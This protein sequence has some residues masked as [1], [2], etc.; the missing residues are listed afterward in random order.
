MKKLSI[1]IS[2]WLLASLAMWIASGQTK[3]DYTNRIVHGYLQVGDGSTAGEVKMGE[4]SPGTDYVSWLAPNSLTLTTRYLMPD[5]PP[6]GSQYLSCG[7]PSSSISTCAFS[8]GTGG[9]AVAGSGRGF[10]L[11]GPYGADYSNTA[12]KGANALYGMQINIGVG[13][14]AAKAHLYVNTAQASST[15]YIAVYN[16]DCTTKLTSGSVASATTGAKNITLSPSYALAAGQYYVMLAN[17]TASVTIGAVALGTIGSS[18]PNNGTN[19]TWGTAAN[20]LSGGAMPSACG[21]ITGAN[22]GATA[23]FPY[24]M[25][26]N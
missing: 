9:G 14:T 12:G 22:L 1:A 10:Y 18:G 24:F 2:L 21:A 8:A 15:Q 11:S 13:F 7:T 6:S 23:T 25:L 4:V 5:T 19:P 17:D 26:D 16:S 20:A 3:N